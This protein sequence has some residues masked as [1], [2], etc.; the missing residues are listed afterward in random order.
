MKRIVQRLAVVGSLGLLLTMPGCGLQISSLHTQSSNDT[1]NT[2]ENTPLSHTINELTQ[3]FSA[4]ASNNS[5]GSGS[6]QLSATT[7][8][9][10]P[11]FAASSQASTLNKSRASTEQLSNPVSAKIEL[12][13]QNQDSVFTVPAPSSG[14]IESLFKEAMAQDPYINWNISSYNISLNS[15]NATINVNYR[16]TKQQTDYVKTRVK[17]ILKSIL[18]PGMTDVYKE[19]VIHNWIVSHV[20]YD[21]SLQNETAYDTLTT[22]SAVCQGYALLA[23]RM[24][25]DAGIPTKIVTGTAGGETHMWN[26]VNLNGKWYQL[27]TTWDDPVGDAPS[28][29]SYT[30]FNLTNQELAYS[31]Q[32]NETAFPAANT[33]FI[34]NLKSLVK[35][36]PQHTK[37]YE[38]ILNAIGSTLPVANTP[39]T[40]HQL[41]QQ[42][43]LANKRSADLIIH[44]TQA[45]SSSFMSQADYNL[46]TSRSVSL[47]FTAT[48]YAR[49]AQDYCRVHINFNY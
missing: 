10:S 23:Y 40:A 1:T 7:T 41:I 21:S 47:Q 15:I 32:W 46:V 19:Y 5:E 20:Q 25:I 26:E 14:D 12:H 31:H 6:A 3:W 45:N 2:T 33:D 27:D 8:Q 42:A 13:L 4:A 38:T 39:Q 16:E 30:Y 44:S 22:G 24:L 48:T 43:L 36:D 18:Q 29:L 37:Q 17:Q 11:T 9:T 35:S 49:K 34:S 28:D